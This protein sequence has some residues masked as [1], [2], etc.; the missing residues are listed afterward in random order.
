MIIINNPEYKYESLINYSYVINDITYTIK[1]IYRVKDDSILSDIT[2]V[3]YNSEVYKDSIPDT[4]YLYPSSYD[5]KQVV[6]NKLN[7]YQDIK[8]QDISTS[9]K[10]ISNSLIDGISVVLLVFSIITLI[11]SSIL[12]SILTYI[13]IMEYKHEIGIYK[14][15][16]L[17]N[18][19]I[20]VIFYL[21][22]II[23]TCVSILIS[24]ITVLIIS[25]PLNNYIYNLTG[26][27]NV[28]SLNFGNFLLISFLSITLSVL[29]SSIPIHNIS[30][31][32]IVEIL[33]NE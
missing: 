20:Q 27:I 30:K 13:N 29:S 32:A 22:N 14:S 16:G 4:I 1:G 19:N 17:S 6:I 9:I 3:I 26:L 28:I 15:I 7:E 23:I 31:L 25:I 8:Y 10:S 24:T 5:N 18:F 12:I 21:E 2:G 11:V 33:R